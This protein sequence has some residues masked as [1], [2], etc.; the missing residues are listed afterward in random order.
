M[1]ATAMSALLF[2]TW[3]STLCVTAA[4]S[5]GGHLAMPTALQKAALS[6]HVH[7]SVSRSRASVMGLR[8]GFLD[9][10]FKPKVSAEDPL[11]MQKDFKPTARLDG[12]WE[13]F[14]D[15]ASGEK[16]FYNTA[17]QETLWEAEYAAQYVPEV[18]PEPVAVAAPTNPRTQTVARGGSPFG[19]PGWMQK[20]ASS[21]VTGGASAFSVEL[22]ANKLD[23]KKNQLQKGGFGF[24]FTATYDAR[25]NPAA[26]RKDLKVV[27]KLPTEDEDAITAFDSERLINQQIAGYGG[28]KGVAEF[29][30]TVDLTPIQQQL[31][32]QG[33]GS[34]QGLVWM[35][36]QG[37]TLDNFFDR[38]GGMSPVL[39]TTLSVKTS[40]PVKLGESPST[41]LG[42]LAYIKTDLCKR[43]MGEALLPLVQLHEKGIIHRDMKPQN[44][45]LV[46]N[47][48]VSPFR[49]IDFGSAITKGSKIV[50][51]DFT[52]IYAPPEAPTPH[53][54][55]P[56]A[57]DIYTI[58]IIGLRVLMP[59]LVAGEM[60]LQTFAKVTCEEF[61][62]KNYDFR[63]WAE[64]RTTDPSPTYADMTINAEIKG[65]MYNDPLYS[66]LADMLDRN[67]ANRPTAKECLERL[68]EEWVARDVAMQFGVGALIPADWQEGQQF[69]FGGSFEAGE[70]VVIRRSD[71]SLKYGL[72]KAAGVKGLC[73]VT[74]DASGSFQRAVA[75]ST[76]GKIFI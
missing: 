43:V 49:V 31:P 47:D 37:K 65:L 46:E 30:G 29:L 18:V 19:L 73:D 74:V 60:G 39:A 4:F 5:T 7:G 17:T 45:M 44:I 76:L 13:E 9:N 55:R 35:Q 70:T 12:Q 71:G 6:R 64:G 20:T 32:A 14:V 15:D 63:A 59:S 22:D 66:L 48:K 53:G 36:V 40:P 42:Q 69:T 58:G 10:M 27:V 25:E 38:G 33:L 3:A 21:V 75:P 51:D 61:P 8:M 50:M 11:W 16:Y 56:D 68:G 41:N 54:R 24:V 67:P 72:V 57:Y 23:F 62:D 28:L 1:H 52:E 26:A 34:L 2:S